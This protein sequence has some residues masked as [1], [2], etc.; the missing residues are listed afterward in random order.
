MST[1]FTEA[2]FVQT[3]RHTALTKR[4]SIGKRTMRVTPRR[5]IAGKALYIDCRFFTPHRSISFG[6]AKRNIE[7]TTLAHIFYNTKYC[8][9][10]EIV[11]SLPLVEGAYAKSHP[12][13]RVRHHLLR[14]I[15]YLIRTDMKKLILLIISAFVTGVCSYAQDDD[16]YFVPSKSD[17]AE[18]EPDKPGRATYTPLAETESSNWAENREDYRDVDDYN[19]R[20]HRADTTLRYNDED[21]SEDYGTYTTRIVRFHSP[22]IG[23][24]VSSPYYIDVYDYWYDP[25]YYSTWYDPWYAPWYGWGWHSAYYWHSW[26]WGWHYPHYGWGW[27][28]PHYG[29]GWAHHAPSNARYG[30]NGGWVSYSSRPASGGTRYAGRE[31]GNRYGNGRPSRNFGNNYNNN[32]RPSR[33]YGNDLRPSR[34]YG[35][36][37]DRDSR[38]SRSFGTDRNTSRP[39]RSFE[40]NSSPSRNSGGHFSAPSRN[41]G[42]SGGRSIGGRGRR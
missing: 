7:E 30:H 40:R 20:G 29:W 1:F 24:Y 4:V 10:L 12:E 11:I 32:A 17:K 8:R 5:P 19:R 9:Q 42:G 13:Q 31:Y 18:A 27:H 16:L 35:N 2:E 22:R 3:Y 23:V 21:E 26:G 28:Y 39:S 38:P 14:S 33:N 15:I 34:N 25:W 37:N 41:S 36:S 6:V